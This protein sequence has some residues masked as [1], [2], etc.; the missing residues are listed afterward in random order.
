MKSQKK[1]KKNEVLVAA[2]KYIADQVVSGNT[3]V[4]QDG[5]PIDLY[6][7]SGS[8]TKVILQRG[9]SPSK[10]TLADISPERTRQ[11]EAK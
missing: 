4:L 11:I 2:N 7:K 5:A 6:V 9:G 8:P 10:R 1:A 3:E